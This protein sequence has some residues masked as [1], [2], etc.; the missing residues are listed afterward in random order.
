MYNYSD[1]KKYGEWLQKWKQPEQSEGETIWK[2]RWIA[3]G[4]VSSVLAWIYAKELLPSTWAFQWDSGRD[5]TVE[6]KCIESQNCPADSSLPLY[7]LYDM[8]Y[9]STLPEHT[10]HLVGMFRLFMP[11]WMSV[12]GWPALVHQS[13]HTEKFSAV[14]IMLADVLNT[15]ATKS[16]IQQNF[17]T[18]KCILKIFFLSFLGRSR[19]YFP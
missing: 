13:L 10:D 2:A 14:A 5:Y 19:F 4:R 12:G 3:S 17:W 16:E 7:T 18:Q 8:L 6:D 15:L 9:S 11:I 1:F